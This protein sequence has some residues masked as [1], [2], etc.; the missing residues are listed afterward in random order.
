MSTIKNG[1]VELVDV[2]APDQVLNPDGSFTTIVKVRTHYDV[3]SGTPG[4][5]SCRSLNTPCDGGGIGDS[6]GYCAV[7]ELDVNGETRSSDPIC[8][9]LPLPGN[10]IPY[11]IEVNSQVPDGVEEA[12]VSGRV[13]MSF[14]GE[15]T[16]YMSDDIVI[17]EDA[18]VNPVDPGNGDD[19]NGG[20]GGGG[21]DGLLQTIIENPGASLI[22]GLGT[23][24][25]LNQAIGE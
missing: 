4:E 9:R 14:S 1:Q 24:V 10:S 7:V 13:V 12:D 25:A 20:N 23:A 15:S 16:A 18:P 22:V 2:I 19:G 3:F 21:G 11:D 5:D 6:N 8:L 17:S